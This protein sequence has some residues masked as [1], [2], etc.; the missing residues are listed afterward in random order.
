MYWQMQGP[1]GQFPPPPPPSSSGG[2]PQCRQ[3]QPLPPLLPPPARQHFPPQPVSQGNKTNDEMEDQTDQT[4][5]SDE[6]TQDTEATVDEILIACVAQ[7]PAL[8][9]HRL[10]LS[11]RTMLKKNALWN[12]TSSTLSSTNESGP[13]TP[14]SPIEPVSSAPLHVSTVSTHNASASPASNFSNKTNENSSKRMCNYN[15]FPDSDFRR[16]EF[17]QQDF[18]ETKSGTLGMENRNYGAHGAQPFEK[19]RKQD[20]RPSKSDKARYRSPV[21]QLSGGCLMTSALKKKIKCYNS[22]CCSIIPLTMADDSDMTLQKWKEALHYSKRAARYFKMK[23]AGGGVMKAMRQKQQP[24]PQQ[25]QRYAGQQ[26]DCEPLE[27]QKHKKPLFLNDYLGRASASHDVAEGG[28][29]FKK[30]PEQETYKN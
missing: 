21:L 23:R 14:P 26:T 17:A 11:E 30:S 4:Y 3:Y 8:Y 20:E 22:I 1:Q 10:P 6:Q 16:A 2:S 9:D 5:I 28:V 13:P 15:F 25:L 18:P 19:L 7:K 12:E 27:G 24:K 29:F